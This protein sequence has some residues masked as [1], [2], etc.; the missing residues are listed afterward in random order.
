MRT[1]L[2]PMLDRGRDTLVEKVTHFGFGTLYTLALVIHP[3]AV[4]RVLQADGPQS[5]A[6][7]Y[8][9]FIEE[10]KPHR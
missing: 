4:L 9:E 7:G 6:F 10:K 3:L 8:Q 1:E 5:I 2:E